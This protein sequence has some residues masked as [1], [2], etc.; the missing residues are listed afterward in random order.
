MVCEQRSL[1]CT[2]NQENPVN[3]G[4]VI[5]VLCTTVLEVA[6]GPIGLSE[7]PVDLSGS[8]E[9]GSRCN[10]HTPRGDLTSGDSGRTFHDAGGLPG[11]AP[12][13]FV[14]HSIRCGVTTASGKELFGFD[15]DVIFV[16]A[17]R[18][19][20]ILAP[21][22]YRI[23]RDAAGQSAPFT[24]EVEVRMP[25]Y[26]K[27]SAGSGIGTFFKRVKLTGISGTLDI[28]RAD[29]LRV[30]ASSGLNDI[31]NSTLQGTFHMRAVRGWDP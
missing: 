15:R 9:A 7:E 14:V 21:G 1:A 8:F 24:T 28:T 29:T 19:G 4:L 26:D 20:E 3:R 10:A 6:C 22:R 12:A 2:T 27:G 17:V 16:F 25:V 13:G 23:V 5:G 30:G 11:V 18:D 31:E